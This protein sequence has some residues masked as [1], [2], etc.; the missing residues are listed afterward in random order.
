MLMIT[1]ALEII[2]MFLD[3][4]CKTLHMFKEFVTLTWL[5]FLGSKDANTLFS[6]QAQ[7]ARDTGATSV[8]C[9]IYI[10]I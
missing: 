6:D 7:W 10:A 3:L 4:A 5:N 1:S 9:W 2:L 8:F